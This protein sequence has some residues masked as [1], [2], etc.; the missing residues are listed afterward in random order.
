[1]DLSKI[2]I[3]NSNM[4]R[5]A[6]VM[7]HMKNTP[8][9]PSPFPPTPDRPPPP[10]PPEEELPTRTRS[11]T[12]LTGANMFALR[13]GGGGGGGPPPRTAPVRPLPPKKPVPVPPK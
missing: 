9:P 2:Q 5:H 10:V 6:S 11:R 4:G 8:S 7:Y 13:G 1:M 3:R 12:D